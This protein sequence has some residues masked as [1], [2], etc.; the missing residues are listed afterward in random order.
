[1]NHNAYP[2]MFLAAAQDRI[3]E[4]ELDRQRAQWRWERMQTRRGRHRARSL[5]VADALRRVRRRRDGRSSPL[6]AGTP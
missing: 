4:L 6:H 5:G 2:E 1:M 3:R